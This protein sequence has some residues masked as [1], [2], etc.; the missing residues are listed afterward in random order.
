MLS[1]QP[2]SYLR[3]TRPASM[4]GLSNQAHYPPSADRRLESYL[5]NA[6]NAVARRPSI[7]PSNDPN[8]FRCPLGNHWTCSR[9][10]SSSSSVN[11]PSE[12]AGSFFALPFPYSMRTIS[13]GN[14]GNSQ[15]SQFGVLPTIHHRLATGPFLQAL[16]GP[17]TLW[18]A[19]DSRQSCSKPPWG[20]IIQTTFLLL[21]R[22]NSRRPSL[23]L[24]P[25]PTVVTLWKQRL[26]LTPKIVFSV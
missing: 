9:I 10:S 18:P 19:Q 2:I 25:P 4:T 8:L 16:S 7:P 15:P 14:R 3:E 24:W 6:F 21:I 5:R 11:L 1:P 23:D 26:N 13:H 17:Q 20:C 22:T 12:S